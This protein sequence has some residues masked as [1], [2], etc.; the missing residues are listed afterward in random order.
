MPLTSKEIGE[1][2][3]YSARITVDATLR[4]LQNAGLAKCVGLDD[5]AGMASSAKLWVGE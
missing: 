2:L 5:G 1:T 3:G 4:E